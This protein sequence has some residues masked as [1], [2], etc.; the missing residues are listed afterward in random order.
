MEYSDIIEKQNTEHIINDNYGKQNS[1]SDLSKT[2][3]KQLKIVMNTDLDFQSQS[4]MMTLSN[5]TGLSDLQSLML[6][7]NF[8]WH[9]PVDGGDKT[10]LLSGSGNQ[11]LC[12][13]CWA[14][15]SAG[16]VGDN[17]VVAGTVDYMPDLSTTY[18]LSC[19]PQKQCKGGNPAELFTQISTHGIASNSCVD[20]SWCALNDQCNG[21]ATNHFKKSQNIELSTLIPTCGCYYSDDKH[22]LYKIE[23]PQNLSIDNNFSESDINHFRLVVKNHI[24]TYGPI[25]GGFLV[26]KNFMDGV[27]SKPTNN[28]GV[29]LENGV[30]DKNGD[31]TFFNNYTSPN[32]YVGGHAISIVGWGEKKIRVDNT[33]NLQNVPYWVCKNSWTDKWGDKGLFKMAMYPFNKISQ[34]DKV[35]Y[36]TTK[37]SQK[38]KIGGMVLIKATSPP[39][40]VKLAQIENTGNSKRLKPASFYKKE[41]KN[42]KGN[43]TIRHKSESS[44][45]KVILKVLLIVLIVVIILIV[46]CMGIVFFIKKIKHRN[47]IFTKFNRD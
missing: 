18:S 5:Q 38:L 42:I 26:F 36:F 46:I 1:L 41:Y 8:N 16:I 32:N 45:L 24:K 33:K 10:K 39:E 20:Y 47:R 14:I 22:L 43:P 21:K 31:L 40:S 15:S 34:F 17:H 29:Y 7:K 11:M 12:G 28:G 44:I 2:K 35:S 13:S 25:L 23:K 3:K 9:N 37:Q 27:F 4:Q 30:Y 19:F 6:P